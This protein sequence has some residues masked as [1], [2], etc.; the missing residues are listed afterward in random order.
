MARIKDV[1][2]AA[3]VST[4]TVSRVLSGS[5]PVRKEL[6]EKVLET[7]AAMGYRPNLA[8]RRLRSSRTQTIGLIVSDV[9]NPFFTNI[10]RAV[11]DMAYQQGMRVMLCN[12]DEDPKKEALYLELME[13]ENVC[14]VIF[15]PTLGTARRF[16]ATVYPFPVVMID[17][18]VAAGTADAVI[19][20]NQAATRTLVDHLV[21]QGYRRISGIFGSASGTG[22]AR[23]EGFNEALKQNGLTGTS[24][25]VTANV[26]A[27]QL[28]ISHLLESPDRP[29]ALLVSNGLFLLGAL[30]A[31]RAAGL[32]IP[33]DVALVG[34]DDDPWTSLVEPGLT[35]IAQPTYEIGRTAMELLLQRRESPERPVR[36][37]ELA[38][39]L[40]KRGSSRI[41]TAG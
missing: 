11:E 25:L 20:D 9:R 37:V 7:V 19:L 31:I 35:V 3:G 36:V 13:D 5:G 6:R 26:A 12:S 23:R 8:A 39:T 34:F 28:E 24:Q 17:R 22:L 14:G 18:P 2:L 27:G 32:S 21:S 33:N 40:I 15:S 10:S 1:A 16:D 38:G 30:Q 41:L 29:E 4:A